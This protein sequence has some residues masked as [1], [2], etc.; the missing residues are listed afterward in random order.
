MS[1]PI[2][3]HTTQVFQPY[4]DNMKDSVLKNYIE[5]RV[6]DQIRWYSKKSSVNQKKYKRYAVISI[7]LNGVI[8]IVVLLSD[9]CAEWSFWL[10]LLI[11]ALSSAAGILSALDALGNHKNLWVQYRANCEQLK[12]TLHLFFMRAGIFEGLTDDDPATLKRKLA[13][14]CEH[15]FAAEYQQWAALTKESTQ[16]KPEKT[17]E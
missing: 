3:D 16:S 4:L 12:S 10:K 11:T 9:Y 7:V 14:A 5:N 2:N 8:P 17:K 6:M 1:E 15:L 13:A